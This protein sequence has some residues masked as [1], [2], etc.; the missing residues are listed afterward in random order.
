MPVLALRVH[1]YGMRC[2]NTAMRFSYT[3]RL[4]EILR[5]QCAA[6]LGLLV[7]PA[8][9]G[10][11]QRTTQPQPK[12]SQVALRK[13]AD[14]RVDRL[15]KFFSQLHCPVRSLAEDFVVAADENHI[16]WRLL[17]S[18]SV[19]ES[20]GGKAYRN[21][22]IFGWS[23]GNVLFTSIRHS[24]HEIAYKLGRSPLYR[25]QDTLGKLKIYNSDAEYAQNVLDVM[26]RIAPS[27]QV[28]S[29]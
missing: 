25:Q 11:Q 4:N 6:V 8:M 9:A 29:F 17:P 27:P 28:K 18:I 15:S 19:I 12:V 21:N 2:Y 24:I 22:N 5:I 20:G 26:N 23:N 1:A 3:P 14:P 10:V 13:S 7:V 16:D